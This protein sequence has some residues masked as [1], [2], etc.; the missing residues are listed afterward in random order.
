MAWNNIYDLYNSTLDDDKTLVDL[1]ISEIKT[2]IEN[3]TDNNLEFS[4]EYDMST[5]LTS[6]PDIQVDRIRDNI[7]FYLRNIGIR[8]QI[9]DVKKLLIEWIIR[10][11]RE[12]MKAYY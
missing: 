7:V 1:I 8:C 6:S 10:E 2:E 5:I 4:F 12:F 3:R 11:N 9:T